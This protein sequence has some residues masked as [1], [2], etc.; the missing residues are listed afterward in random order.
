VTQTLS[1]KSL[2]LCTLGFLVSLHAW[3]QQTTT[4][5][6][7]APAHT[8]SVVIR[9]LPDRME[10]AQLTVPPGPLTI[11]V[12]NHSTAPNVKLSLDDTAGNNLTAVSLNPVQHHFLQAYNFAPG[13]YV[14]TEKNHSKWTCTITVNGGN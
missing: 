7:T 3:P 8:L 4:T 13:T 6:Q 2:M 9:I 11:V 14:L 12:L 5:L 1:G 10:P